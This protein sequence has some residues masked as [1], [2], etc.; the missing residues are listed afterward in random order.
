MSPYADVGLISASLISP[1]SVALRVAIG[2]FLGGL[3]IFVAPLYC[4]AVSGKNEFISKTMP[5][6]GFAMLVSWLALI[7]A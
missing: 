6:G 5:I 7:F 3:G 4:M 2:G 1:A